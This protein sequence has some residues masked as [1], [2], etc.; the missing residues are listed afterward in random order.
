MIT[1]LSSGKS[2]ISRGGMG[3]P[4]GHLDVA[5]LAADVHVLAHR[6][7]DQR[8][9]AAERRGGVD[10]LL[11]AM[12]V[13]GE[14]GD[15]DAALA[16]R[17]RPPRGAGRRPTRSARSPRGRRWSS[18]PHS[19]SSPS[20]P[21]SARRAEVGGVA[22]DRRLVELVV[23]GD[24]RRAERCVQRDRGGV[25]DRV[26]HVHE[27]EA[28]RPGLERA[29]PCSSSSSLTSLEPVLVELGARHR[30]GERA[31]VDGRSLIGPELAQD[32]RQRAE[33]VLVAVGHD[34]RL[35]VLDAIAQ[36]GEVG[37]HEVDPEHVGGREAQPARRRRRCGRRARRPSCSCRSPR[38]RRAGGCGAALTRRAVRS[39][40]WRSST[41]RTWRRARPRSPRRAAAAA[42]RPRCRAC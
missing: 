25:G 40:P 35:D 36:V 2:S 20:W 5:E 28:E 18:R 7:A 38:D 16:A 12:D 6:A 11:D 23:A 21:S 33:V 24:E 41:A 30:H 13:R 15:D 9:L 4:V 34:D 32:P 29:C 31:A 42:R 1:S 19:S 3:M 27:L 22:V 37:Q 39:K 8:D 26:G 17:R 10:D 14:A